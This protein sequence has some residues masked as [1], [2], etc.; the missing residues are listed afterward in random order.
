MKKIEYEI[1]TNLFDP[2]KDIDFGYH[3]KQYVRVKIG[4]YKEDIAQ[5][6]KVNKK[7]VIVQIVPRINFADI[8]DR[9]RQIEVEYAKI[10]IKDDEIGRAKN[11]RFRQL[12]DPKGSDRNR[13][14]KKKLTPADF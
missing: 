9:M 14:D 1:F 2:R 10:N 4:R 11:E 12:V 8:Q 6:T 7:G 3:V 13:A 5:I